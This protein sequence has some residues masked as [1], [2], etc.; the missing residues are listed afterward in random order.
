MNLLGGYKDAKRVHLFFYYR[1]KA[2]HTRL[3][4]VRAVDNMTDRTC[5][6]FCPE[7]VTHIKEFFALVQAPLRTLFCCLSLAFLGR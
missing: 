3:A 6:C 2:L 7:K 1:L 4:F 5:D